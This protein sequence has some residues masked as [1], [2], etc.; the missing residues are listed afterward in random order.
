MQAGARQNLDSS[1]KPSRGA[2][3]YRR[4]FVKQGERRWESRKREYKPPHARG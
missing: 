1:K 2:G 4:D 3:R